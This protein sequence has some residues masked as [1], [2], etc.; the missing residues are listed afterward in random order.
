MSTVQEEKYN[1][2]IW[3]F[4]A[5]V[6][7]SSNFLCVTVVFFYAPKN[8]IFETFFLH[9]YCQILKY[10]AKEKDNV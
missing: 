10:D 1:L 9:F 3:M 5:D 2:E 7:D 8:D 6:I 4:G